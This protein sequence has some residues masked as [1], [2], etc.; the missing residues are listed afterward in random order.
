MPRANTGKIIEAITVKRKRIL[1]A[2]LSG[3]R[4]PSHRTNTP[5]IIFMLEKLS[6]KKTTSS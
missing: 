4:L 5:K 6:R 2:F 3:K 1:I